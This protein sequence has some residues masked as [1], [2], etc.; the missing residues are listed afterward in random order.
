M[1]LI[2]TVILAAW[3]GAWVLQL[4][5]T[6]YFE[7]FRSEWAT[8]LYWFIARIFVWIL[9][10][11]WILKKYNKKLK[12]IL[13]IQTLKHTLVWGFG[14]G[15][16]FLALHITYRII[17][18]NLSILGDR[19]L[20]TFIDFVILAPVF[21]EFLMRGAILSTLKQKFYF[22]KANTITAFLFVLLHCPGWYFMGVL[23]LNFLNPLTGVLAIFIIGFMCGLAAERGKSLYSA[24]IVHMLNNIV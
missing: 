11:F 13:R 4:A 17:N 8:F 1:H 5:L 22:L 9:P 19:S 12:D 15:G 7:L 23:Q 3:T 14:I 20:L 18:G 2:F 21:E 10:A 24:M 6:D 16:I